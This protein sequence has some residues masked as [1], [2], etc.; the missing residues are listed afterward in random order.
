MVIF[1]TEPLVAAGMVFL[2][3]KDLFSVTEN[4]NLKG[5][6]I[7]ELMY[8]RSAIADLSIHCLKH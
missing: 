7:N 2:D 4:E 8:F 3:A 6:G 1:P 5:W